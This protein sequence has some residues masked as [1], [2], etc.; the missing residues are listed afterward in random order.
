MRRGPVRAPP[1]ILA[2]QKGHISMGRWGDREGP[3]LLVEVIVGVF[4][5]S[6][7][8]SVFIKQPDLMIPVGEIVKQV[9]MEFPLFILMQWSQ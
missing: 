9:A 5:V 4:L 8:M 3:G 7:F 1:V 6:G 2:M